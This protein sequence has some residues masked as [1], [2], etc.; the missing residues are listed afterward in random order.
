MGT[1]EKIDHLDGD[2]CLRHLDPEDTLSL[3]E[4]IP[5]DEVRAAYLRI[6]GQGGTWNS[7]ALHQAHCEV[8]GKDPDY[9]LMDQPFTE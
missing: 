5:D 4:I 7:A 6:V 2:I 3:E 9:E 1:P 8:H